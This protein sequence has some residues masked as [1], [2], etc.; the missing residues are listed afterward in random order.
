MSLQTEH[1]RTWKIIICGEG[2]VGKT[3]LIKTYQQ[4]S[5]YTGAT[6]TVAVQFHTLNL[7]QNSIDEA[8]GHIFQIWDLGGQRQYY[9]M[10]VFNKYTRE[11]DLSVCC[12]D[13]NDLETLEEIPRWVTILDESVP[14]LLVGLKT[15]LITNDVLNNIIDLIEDY[16]Q[17][18]GF[19]SMH[20]LS[21]KH[22]NEV[23]TFFQYITDLLLKIA[24]NKFFAKGI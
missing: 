2:A 11:A 15:D 10:N 17:S 9:D 19:E 3:T 23:N 18:F 5:F 6:E 4:G 1:S 13:V 21:S 16:K 20:L 7:F 14:R 8:S 22:I 12:F 24:E